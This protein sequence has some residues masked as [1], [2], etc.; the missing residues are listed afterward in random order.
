[1]QSE[2]VTLRRNVLFPPHHGALAR[3]RSSA[4]PHCCRSPM[5]ICHHESR[6][7]AIEKPLHLTHGP[8][9]KRYPDRRK[10]NQNVL[11]VPD[12]ALPSGLCLGKPLQRFPH[13]RHGRPTA[14]AL[15]QEVDDGSVRR[16]L[17]QAERVRSGRQSRLRP[18][19]TMTPTLDGD[20]EDLHAHAC[21]PCCQFSDAAR[22]LLASFPGVW[23]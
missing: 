12:S 1:M 3:V 17:L 5:T 19:R 8:P 21:R 22:R 7:S 20:A 18:E 14:S 10:A 23:A 9:R 2:P 6:L 4:S 16:D 15:F 13:A 11:G